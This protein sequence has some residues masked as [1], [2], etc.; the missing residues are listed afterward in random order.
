MDD[1]RAAWP[2]DPLAPLR[3]LDAA[4]S[5][6]ALLPKGF[7]LSFRVRC[8]IAL[9]NPG[10]PF[11]CAE[12]VLA[13]CGP[14]APDSE[15][16]RLIGRAADLV[17]EPAFLSGRVALPS[18]GSAQIASSAVLASEQT[19]SL[20][21]HGFAVGVVDVF[22]TQ[23]ESEETAKAHVEAFCAH[24]ARHS[25]S[26]SVRIGLF[27]APP[28]CFSSALALS[29]SASVSAWTHCSEAFAH[30]CA[31]A[32]RARRERDAIAAAISSNALSGLVETDSGSTHGEEGDAQ[33]RGGARRL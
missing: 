31:H 22:L 30:A 16:L 5:A 29:D 25:P 32:W 28:E 10:L 13:L 7:S 18:W 3:G 6:P 24:F 23:A 21:A 1:T 26:R 27:C 12:T 2:L 4:R 11:A 15:P 14:R 19:E 33:G 8:P 17:G 9:R 20:P